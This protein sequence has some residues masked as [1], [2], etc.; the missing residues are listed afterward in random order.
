MKAGWAF[1]AAGAIG[2]LSALPMRWRLDRLR[3]EMLEARAKLVTM[4]LQAGKIKALR[5]STSARASDF[6]ATMEAS[7]RRRGVRQQ[8]SSIALES[9]SSVSA[10]LEAVPFE[11]VL[12]W[13]EDLRTAGIEVRQAAFER[14]P[15]SGKVNVRLRLI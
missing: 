13:L 3:R 15:E 6:V 9:D 12:R 11:A 5:A 8:I 7:A 1:A 4:R 10:V 14:H 2:L